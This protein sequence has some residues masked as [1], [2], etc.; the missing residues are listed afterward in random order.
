V[1]VD[2]KQSL[3][4]QDLERTLADILFLARET[5]WHYNTTGEDT[6]T[7]E[8]LKHLRAEYL[9]FSEA[10]QVYHQ[11][12]F[13][14]QKGQE[15][16]R[17][18]HMDNRTVLISDPQLQDKAHRY[19]VKEGLAL[20]PG[21]LLVSRFDLNI[22]NKLIELPHRPM[23][24]FCF[25]LFADKG[26][27]IGLLVMNY[28]GRNLIE[29]L[30]HF[31]GEDIVT[32]KK[33]LLNAQGY[34]L[35]GGGESR[36]WAFMYDDK[37]KISFAEE[38]PIPWAAIAASEAGQFKYDGGLYTY[39]TIRM[40]SS[41]ADWP[42]V[43]HTAATRLLAQDPHWKLVSYAPLPGFWP[44]A[45]TI[46]ALAAT[47]GISFTALFLLVWL[48]NRSLMSRRLAQ[49]QL[50]LSEAE[51]QRL[52]HN[53]P[54]VVY[55]SIRDPDRTM[56]FV[57]K[58]VSKLLGYEPEEFIGEKALAFTSLIAP[59]DRA[60]VAEAISKAVH[61]ET[62]YDIEY[63]LQDAKGEFRWVYDSGQTFTPTGRP[64]DRELHG[65]ILDISDMKAAE[66]S[67]QKAR[68]EAE[69][70]NQAKSRFLANMSHEIRTPMNAI[71][72]ISQSIVEKSVGDCPDLREGVQVIYK[73]GQRLLTLINGILDLSKIEAG[74]AQPTPEP[75]R[76]REAVDLILTTSSSLIGPKNIDLS[77]RYDDALP[78]TIV[79]DPQMVHQILTNMIGNAIKFT[80]KGRV[81]LSV[82]YASGSLDFTLEDTGIGMSEEALKSIFEEF[83]Q[84]D[85]S[86]VRKYQ[87]SG[88]GLSIAKSFIELLGGEISVESRPGEG[89][90]F[91][92]TIP[93]EIGEKKAAPS[94]D[95]TPDSATAIPSSGEKPRLLIAEDDQFNQKAIAMMLSDVCEI[96]FANNGAEALRALVG[97]AFDLV[98]TDIEMPVMD[99]CTFIDHVRAQYRDLPTP[100]VAMT[101]WAMDDDR[102]AIMGHGFDDYITKPLDYHATLALIKK[103]T[104]PLAPQAA[105]R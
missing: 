72:S 11:I 105:S 7:P 60:R 29:N 70:A 39:A 17:V 71:M 56:L 66:E 13:I 93:V 88:L 59:E 53:I 51:Y 57:S 28:N 1:N 67:L 21:E 37:Q 96:T 20:Q 15:I 101:A 52:V 104:S 41:H 83:R 92:F 77:A 12:R 97:G 5:L 61:G 90:T 64:E 19:Y 24:R 75:F 36:D 10:T 48:L 99:G 27:R 94:D 46:T 78:D 91:H 18:D 102:K 95:R 6:P 103:Y 50:A 32:T 63:R 2:L 44:S 89:T 55:Q 34:W 26:N 81:T 43:S 69:S 3:F 100:I 40:P 86:P 87:G 9:H 58:S 54:G 16:V 62:Y 33:F 84:L 76:L 14:G 49:E 79:S 25:P 85:S 31:G 65:V 68:R 73:S 23:L 45:S 8:S 74:K 22:E 47:L 42:L 38:H 80:E 4:A 35:S 82:R 30:I 98:L